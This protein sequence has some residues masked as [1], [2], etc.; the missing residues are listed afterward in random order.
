MQRDLWP[1][2]GA[3]PP[4]QKPGEWNR[5]TITCVGQKLW[6][7]LNNEMIIEMDMS[8]WTSAKVNP[9]GSE[10]PAWL[11]KPLAELPLRGRHWISRQARR[12]AHLVQEHQDQRALTAR[13]QAQKA[14]LPLKITKVTEHQVVVDIFCIILVCLCTILFCC[15]AN[16]SFCI[17]LIKSWMNHLVVFALTPL[18]T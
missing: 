5:Y 13:R 16:L 10:I 11:N 18:G 2:S 3:N 17:A 7:R 9:D 1:L 4:G 6:V 12:R 14:F 15:L 8:R